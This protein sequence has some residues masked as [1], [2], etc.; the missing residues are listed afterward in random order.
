MLTKRSPMYKNRKTLGEIVWRTAH[1]CF[2]QEHLMLVEGIMKI[3]ESKLLELITIKEI[4]EEMLR[5]FLCC[6]SHL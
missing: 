1:R 5:E 6:Y 4:G 2:L 3:K